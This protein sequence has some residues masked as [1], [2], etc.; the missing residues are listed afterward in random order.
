MTPQL[1]NQPHRLPFYL[2]AMLE[3]TCAKLLRLWISCRSPQQTP[4]Q[5]KNKYQHFFMRGLI[6]EWCCSG[7]G[8]KE[9]E[10][11]S[12]G[13][14]RVGLSVKVNRVWLCGK[15]ESSAGGTSV[16]LRGWATLPAMFVWVGRLA[17]SGAR[18]C[19]CGTLLVRVWGKKD[20]IKAEP[21]FRT[22]AKWALGGRHRGCLGNII[23]LS[24]FVCLED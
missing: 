14:E 1:A 24:V 10:A 23:S 8:G 15:A 17:V 5:L 3:N 22:Y 11:A 16:G 2:R 7:G 4:T 19:A 9:G 20:K 21:A 6:V 13:C 18:S 12:S